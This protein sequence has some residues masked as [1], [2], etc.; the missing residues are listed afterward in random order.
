MSDLTATA[1]LFIVFLLMLIG[2]FLLFRASRNPAA[3]RKGSTASDDEIA[4][5]PHRLARIRGETAPVDPDR[6]Q[7]EAE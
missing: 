5:A 2:A 7:D 1:L 4:I 3:P 6:P